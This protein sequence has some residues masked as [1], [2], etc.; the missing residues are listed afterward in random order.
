MR[1]VRLEIRAI[2]LLGGAV[3]VVVLFNQALQLRETPTRRRDAS[4][5]TERRQNGRTLAGPVPGERGTLRTWD[6]ILDSLLFG[7][8]Y[9]LSGTRAALR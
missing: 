9:S 8:T 2:A 3:E 1:R 7:K 4:W 6:W 5:P